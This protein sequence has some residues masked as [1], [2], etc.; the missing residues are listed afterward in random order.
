MITKEQ[1]YQLM[2]N[3]IGICGRICSANK[4]AP[5]IIYNANIIIEGFGKVWY[6]DF[7]LKEE[8][9]LQLIANK[10]QKKMY[11]LREHDARFENEVNPKLEKAV[12]T[13]TP[14]C[15]VK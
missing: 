8:S 2:D 5:N 7:K 1:I 3:T 9:E 12:I 15:E 6:G 13:V 11:V 4:S 14:K 10:I